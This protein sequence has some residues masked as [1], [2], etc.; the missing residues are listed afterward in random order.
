MGYK[1]PTLIDDQCTSGKKKVEDNFDWLATVT[2][3]LLFEVI[4]YVS[5]LWYKLSGHD[6][7]KMM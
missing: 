3:G 5:F 7:N 1:E 6:N 2:Q 4:A